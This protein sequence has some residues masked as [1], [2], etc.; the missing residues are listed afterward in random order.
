[1]T[2]LILWRAAHNHDVLVDEVVLGTL[3]RYYHPASALELLRGRPM[4]ATAEKV[5]NRLSPELLHQ[6]AVILGSHAL[7]DAAK[8]HHVGPST[9]VGYRIRE[10]RSTPGWLEGDWQ[11]ELKL[12]RGY[13]EKAWQTVGGRS[14]RTTSGPRH[15]HHRTPRRTTTPH[16]P[17]GQTDTGCGC[18]T[19]TNS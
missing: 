16:C 1:M 2:A 12:A 19:H 15:R 6:T 3:P 9:T 17:P 4:P 18:R 10:L 5:V 11:E 13:R 14:P 7:V 8:P